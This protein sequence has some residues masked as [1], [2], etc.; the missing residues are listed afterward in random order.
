VLTALLTSD[1]TLALP[2]LHKHTAVSLD[3]RGARSSSSLS[4][5]ASFCVCARR[6]KGR[7]WHI[8]TDAAALKPKP[9]VTTVD[10]QTQV[11]LQ[12]SC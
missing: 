11:L 9:L 10:L 3:S 2:T 7:T 5:S 4:A 12:Y 1:C 6:K 8:L